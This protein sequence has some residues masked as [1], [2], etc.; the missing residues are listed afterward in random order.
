MQELQGQ[1]RASYGS[2]LL[3]QKETRTRLLWDMGKSLSWTGRWGRPV[4]PGELADVEAKPKLGI[5][6]PEE[7]A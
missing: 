4:G 7:E 5:F 6:I 1:C 2:A 3:G